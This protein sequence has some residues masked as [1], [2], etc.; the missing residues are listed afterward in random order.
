MPRDGK[1]MRNRILETAERMVLHR[2]FSGTSIE[3]LLEELGVT[4]GT[5]FYHFKSKRELALALIER[6]AEQDAAELE[7]FMARAENLATDPLQQLLVFVGLY[8]EMGA[9]LE[10]PPDGCLFGAYSYEQALFDEEIREV[11][12]RS[13][14]AWRVRV[15]DKIK[16]VMTL[17]PPR[18]PVAAEDVADALVSALEGAFVL[19]KVF[20]DPKVFARQLRQY[21]NYVE[22]LFGREGPPLPSES[23]D[24]AEAEREGVVA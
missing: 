15:G 12:V 16:E 7:T 8:E 2:G 1:I 22:L 9:T 24:A 6:H 20:E 5:F 23:A 18:L 14:Q 10:K 19:G 13:L 21:R 4:K 11:S 17:Y 3:L